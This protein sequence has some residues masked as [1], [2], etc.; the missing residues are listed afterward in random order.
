[1]ALNRA[2]FA[3]TER[4]PGVPVACPRCVP[5]PML[6][7]FRGA[8]YDDRSRAGRRSPTGGGPQPARNDEPSDAREAAAT[9]SQVVESL[10]PPAQA[11][12]LHPG[13]KMETR[14]WTSIRRCRN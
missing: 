2:T 13:N 8:R 11:V 6:A 12:P 9:S 3:G 14:A 4:H 5:E 10:A 1:M 7:K